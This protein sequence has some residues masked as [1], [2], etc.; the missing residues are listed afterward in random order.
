MY[1]C[2]AA[3]EIQAFLCLK[4]DT[5]PT[6]YSDVRTEAQVVEVKSV[7]ALLLAAAAQA[8]ATVNSSSR[9]SIIL[10]FLFL[11]TRVFQLLLPRRLQHGRAAAVATAPTFSVAASSG[12]GTFASAEGTRVNPLAAAAICTVHQCEYVST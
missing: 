4:S 8:A 10:F 12:F 9:I 3:C 1:V 6:K 2:C 7:S 5:R 11:F